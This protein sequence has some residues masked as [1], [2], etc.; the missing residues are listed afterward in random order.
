MRLRYAG[1]CRTCGRALA[2]GEWAI[3]DRVAKNVECP[4]CPES[5]VDPASGSLVPPADVHPETAEPETVAPAVV[6]VAVESG[7]AGASARREHGRR[8]A[9]RD[10]GV[11]A[12]HPRI[13]GLILALTD[14]PQHIRSWAQGAPGE[15]LVGRKLDELT[16]RGVLLLHDRRIPPGRTNIDHIAI[17]AAGVFVIDAKR[18]KGKRPTLRVQGGILRAR[19]ETLLVG[20]RDCGKLVAGVTKQVEIVR[21]A[22]TQAGL[23]DVPVHGMLCFVEADWPLFGGS[24]PTGGIDVLWPAKATENIT[25]DGPLSGDQVVALHRHLADTF[26]P[27]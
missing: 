21:I 4:T 19:T 6:P 12:A 3:Y 16:D 15:E 9:K 13:G 27:A 20:G 7:V 10:A 5:D 23:T 25:V 17:S 11:R 26:P 1:T 14:E 2:A 22:V 8:A 18:Y 24:F